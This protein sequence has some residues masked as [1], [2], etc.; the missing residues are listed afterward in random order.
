MKKLLKKVFKNKCI[1]G[2]YFCGT[3][4]GPRLCIFNCLFLE[5][6]DPDWWFTLFK[7]W[8]FVIIKL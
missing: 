3:L 6:G 1:F 7:E 5:K 4:Q 8:L 2:D